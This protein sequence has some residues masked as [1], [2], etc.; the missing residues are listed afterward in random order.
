MTRTITTCAGIGDAI[1]LFQKLI[2]A[3]EKF[4]W[5]IPDGTPQRGKQI[6]DLM[7]RIAESCEYVPKLNYSK[8]KNNCATIS[9]STWARITEHEF[10][11][12]ANAHLE[13]GRRIEQFLPD[14]ETTYRLDYATSFEDK[15]IAERLLPN[16]KYIGIYTSAYG[17]AR[18]WGF[19][20]EHG[21][22]KLVKAIHDVDKT[23]VFVLIGADWDTDLST[24][25][26]QLM[27]EH[28]IQFIN[29]V[30]K[31]LSVVLECMK[32][33]SYAFYFPSGLAI[34]SE[35]AGCSDSVMFYPKHKLPK[36]PGT[37]CDP[38]RGRSGAFKECFFCEAEEIFHWVKYVYQLF[39][40]N[41]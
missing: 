23:F 4:H 34:L 19:W 2:N 15:K 26:M 38:Q 22:F 25:L 24:K 7:P 14:L 41:K 10:F 37:W 17:N 36:M 39:E 12:Q 33:L 21:W 3:K 31:P 13:S 16:N 29:T 40:R 11:L 9:R 30:G 5:K 6:F 27:N 35:T 1:F 20:D 32:R 18:H 28:H 8:I